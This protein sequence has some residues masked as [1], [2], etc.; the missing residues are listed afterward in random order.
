MATKEWVITK[1][2]ITSLALVS[3]ISICIGGANVLFEVK[4]GVV[5]VERDIVT[6][7]VADD[8]QWVK[9]WEDV[10]NNTDDIHAIEVN[11]SKQQAQYD[12]LKADLAE[13]KM[14]LKGFEVK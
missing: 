14:I 6:H 5:R 11:D 8:K 10:D 4:R 13:I 1:V 12:S 7:K 2:A 9:V 3:L